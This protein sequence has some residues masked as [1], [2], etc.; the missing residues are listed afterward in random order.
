MQT[1]EYLRR[2]STPG[3]LVERLAPS[4]APSPD[5]SNQKASLPQLLEL[6][7]SRRPPHVAKI[8]W[9]ANCAHPSRAPSPDLG[10]ALVFFLSHPLL[11]FSFFFPPSF[12]SA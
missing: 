8:S 2:A 4:P 10:R 1:R 11:F 9:P 5:D 3:L 12:S 7:I 6:N